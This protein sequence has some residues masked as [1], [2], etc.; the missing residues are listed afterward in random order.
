MRLSFRP[1][2]WSWF[3]TAPLLALLLALGAWQMRRAHEKEQLLAAYAAAAKQ[4]PIELAGASAPPAGAVT[5]AA[6]ARGRYVADRQFLLD[7]QSHRGQPGYQ[8]WTPLRL[9]AG[10][11]VLVNR[12]WVPLDPLRST[13]STLPAP[14]DELIVRGLW[15]ALPQP[16]LKLA[17]PVAA[18]PQ[19]YPAVVEYPTPEDVT[20]LFGEP[21]ADGILL[22]DPA[23]P[24][25][26]L[27][28]WNP[29]GEFPPARHYAYATQW[30]ALA[31][32][33][34]VIFVRM[35]LKPSA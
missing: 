33:L 8:V 14:V 22:L 5:V 3:A 23:E 18:R 7:N 27:R 13:A 25:G 11:L 32:T 28:D 9:S 20:R 17:R 6:Q 10:G 26:F 1:P 35:N 24:G 12:G 16:G 19:K 15:R 31:L 4:T 21:V 34:L 29:V 2:F 30:F